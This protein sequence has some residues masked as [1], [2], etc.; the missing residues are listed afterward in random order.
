MPKPVI[1]EKGVTVISVAADHKSM[2]LP[3]CQIL[4]ALCH[5]PCFLLFQG[6]VQTSATTAIGTIQ[7]MVGLFNIGLGPG[8]TSTYPGDLTSLGAAYWLGAVFIVTGIMSILA[9][10]F[11]SSCLVGFTVFMNIVGAIFAI[12]GIVLYAIDL[13]GASLL[14][15]CDR[16]RNNADHADNCR[17][18]ALLAQKLLTFMDSTLIAMAA[19][20]L[21]VSI[22]FAIL[23]IRALTSEIKKEEGSEDVEDQRPL[24]KDVLLTSPGA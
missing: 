6:P 16:S 5:S 13:T 20:Q 9:G 11:P 8:R 24:L 3:L 18:V 2:F 21:C 1:Q 19:L 23:G 14:W 4:K 17:N 15:I 7:I 10:Q 12:T 22:R